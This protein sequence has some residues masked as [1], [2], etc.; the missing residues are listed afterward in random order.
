MSAWICLTSQSNN[1]MAYSTDDI[2]AL[3]AILKP[4]IKSALESGSTGVGDLEVVTSLDSVYSLPALRMPG[5]IHDVVEAPLSLLR[6]NLRVTTTHVQWKLGNGEWKDLLALSELK[7]VFRRTEKH[8]QWKVGAGSWEDIVELESLKG[9]KGDRGDAF[10]YE[11]F[12]LEQLMGLKGDK[13]D[14]GDNLEYRLLDSFPSLEALRAAYP[15]GTGQD[16]FFIAGDGMYVWDPKDVAYKE[17]KL[18]VDKVFTSEI[19]RE[20]TPSGGRIAIDFL[21]APYAKVALGQDTL[22]YN[23]EIQN[24]R[25]GSCGKVMV[26]QSGLRQIVLSNTMRGTIDLPLN[27]DTIAI[28][29]YNRVGEYI[30]I[31]TSTIIGDKTYPGP[32]KI[33]DF[34]V[35]YSDSSSCTV[36]WTAPYA[37]NIYDRGTEY[38]MR[39]ANDLV[40]ADDPKVWAGLRK[41]PAIPTPENPGTLQRT[42]ISG[43]VPNREYYVYL[44]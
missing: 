17:I 18:E 36:Q 19:F 37:N 4:I 12:T 20:V 33:K 8:L 7:V 22:I 15:T 34:H 35:V 16:G 28:L 24:T 6:V 44:K 40:D 9:E 11:D 43:L 27:S 14:K 25:E 13:G 26:Y 38:D 2:K 1:E 32:Q 21:K 3:A 41:V 29:N 5:G 39:Y 31:H 30:Y 10:R 42:T 23:L